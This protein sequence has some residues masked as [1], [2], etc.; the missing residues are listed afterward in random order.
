LWSI[1][2][3]VLIISASLYLVLTERRNARLAAP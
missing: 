2:G 3:M 1:A